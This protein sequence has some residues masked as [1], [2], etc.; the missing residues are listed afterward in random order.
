MLD[1]FLEWRLWHPSKRISLRDSKTVSF[2]PFLFV[3]DLGLAF[4][5]DL[6]N[7]IFNLVTIFDTFTRFRVLV[8]W[9]RL[10]ENSVCW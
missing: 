4:W 3:V 8:V 5:K 1:N 9:I 10:I 7:E 6:L 2:V